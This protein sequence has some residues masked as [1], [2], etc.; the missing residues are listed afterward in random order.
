MN[1]RTHGYTHKPWLQPFLWT[2]SSSHS[3]APLCRFL[4]CPVPTP[5]LSIFLWVCV[6]AHA[7]IE[8]WVYS[9]IY[10]YV[11]KCI[12]ISECSLNVLY[13][14]SLC[15]QVHMYVNLY[16]YICVYIYMH[17]RMHACMNARTYTYRYAHTH[18]CTYIYIHGH[19]QTRG[20]N[21]L[22]S[23][24]RISTDQHRDT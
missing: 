6:C 13:G 4:A 17:A 3:A 16:T 11:L 2:P 7:Y 18:V 12:G 9:G 5:D 19:V 22:R 1:T 21:T 20:T 8:P 14:I 24:Y 15:T 10:A 23:T